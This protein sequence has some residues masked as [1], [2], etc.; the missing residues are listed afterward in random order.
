[1][2]M[3]IK[4]E[5]FYGQWYEDIPRR[6]PDMSKA[7]ALLDFEPTTSLEEGMRRT[8]DWYSSRA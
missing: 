3:H 6:V 1:M 4:H 2:P 8:W 7:K 5:E